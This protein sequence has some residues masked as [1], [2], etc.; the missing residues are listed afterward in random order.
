MPVKHLFKFDIVPHKVLD[1][2]NDEWLPRV[3]QIEK[4]NG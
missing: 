3:A 4:G 1:L 2:W